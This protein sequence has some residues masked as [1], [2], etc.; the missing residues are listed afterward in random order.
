VRA[1]TL[2]NSLRIRAKLAALESLTARV[3][4]TP[5]RG[6]RR[7]RYLTTLL[8]SEYLSCCDLSA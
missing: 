1:G 8:A 7:P 6:G 2:S 4:S 5:R 3:G